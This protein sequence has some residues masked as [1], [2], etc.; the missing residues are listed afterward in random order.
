MSCSTH[1]RVCCPRKAECSFIPRDYPRCG[2]MTRCSPPIQPTRK[3]HRKASNRNNHATSLTTGKILSCRFQS[4]DYWSAQPLHHDMNLWD[5]FARH[6]STDCMLRGG[7]K[8]KLRRRPVPSNVQ[9][10]RGRHRTF[11]HI[12]GPHRTRTFAMS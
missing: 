9:I 2:H 1:P 11:W 8:D 10:A 3:K 5:N 12:L 4:A 6:P 7:E